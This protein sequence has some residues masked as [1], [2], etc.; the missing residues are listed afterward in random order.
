[1]T[2]P[3][4]PTLDLKAGFELGVSLIQGVQLEKRMIYLIGNGGSAAI[5]SHQAVDLMRN[6]GIRA[7]AF[8]DSAMLTC[9]G[10]DFGYDKVF[11]KPLELLAMREDVLI[12][13]SSSG[14]SKNILGAVEVAKS[15]GIKVVTFSG[16]EPNN[17]LR[18][19]GDLNYY[20]PSNNY[21]IVEV[22]HLLL[23]HTLIDET[24]RRA[25]ELVMASMKMASEIKPGILQ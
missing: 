17:P 4:H 24:I 1:M 23:I 5:A 7:M 18:A 20:V 22:L 12:A 11:S 6:A 14:Q 21:G 8:N 10:N 25:K 19:K 15:I 3:G 9:I 13:V 2:T 16:F